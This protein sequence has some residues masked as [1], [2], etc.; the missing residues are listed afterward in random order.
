LPAFPLERLPAAW[1]AWARETAACAGAP[2]DY[3]AL[4]LL[5][6]VAGVAGA[7]VRAAPLPS[8]REPLVLWQCA[9]GGSGSGKSAALAATRRLVDALDGADNDDRTAP[10]RIVS[11]ATVRALAGVVAR[12]PGGNGVVLWRDEL[13]AWLPGRGRARAGWQEAW[14][15][16]PIV[17]N[18]GVT[19]AR[20]RLKHF[21]V[22][23]I[24]GARP[25][26]LARALK[27]ADDGMAAR[28]LYAWPAKP[29]W[30]P[31]AERLAPD[32]ELALER[33]ERLAGWVG[34]AEAPL[35]LAMDKEAVALF[36]R[37]CR[38][39]HTNAPDDESPF[40]DWLAKAGSQIARLAGVLEL[41][42][43]S[44]VVRA[45]P[46]YVI[47]HETLRNAIA[48]W[49]FYFKPHAEAALALALP[50]PREDALAKVIRWLKKTCA[51]EVSREDIRASALARTVDARGADEII[52]RLEE[53]GVLVR[54][55]AGATRGRGRRPVRW[56]VCAASSANPGNS[57][58]GE[59]APS[60]GHPSHLRTPSTGK[61]GTAAAED[62]AWQ[63]SDLKEAMRLVKML[64]ASP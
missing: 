34:T 46:P 14:S 59:K 53:M 42:D 43:W 10:Q 19:A 25:A 17:V 27:G 13:L 63:T 39:Q 8:W 54:E 20:L 32:D 29:A 64:E 57:P 47:R 38:R 12:N 16:A 5:A 60:N 35:V 37:Y 7:G 23:V 62:A 61:S 4:G 9:V 28:F 51:T 24:G 2:V 56:R 50:G 40:A 52:A 3:V 55:A 48:L 36:E 15:A 6:A 11:E 41:L 31:F 33:F 49:H 45:A 58:E 1:A 21:P 22:S 30:V 18:R 44:Q 26:A